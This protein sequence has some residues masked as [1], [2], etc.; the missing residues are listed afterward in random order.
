MADE[1]DLQIAQD[2]E[3]ERARTW[4]HQHG[5]SIVAGVALG[6]SAVVG[7]NYWQGYTQT[8]AKE[9]AVLYERFQDAIEE[10]ENAKESEENESDDNGDATDEIKEPGDAQDAATEDV[11]EADKVSEAKDNWQVIADDLMQEYAR[12]PYSNLA[13]FRLAKIAV[14]ENNLERAAEV[15]QWVLDNSAAKELSHVARLRLVT[16]KLSQDDAESALELLDTKQDSFRARYL[17]LRGDAELQLGN[18]NSAKNAYE[19]SLKSL[20]PESSAH[21]LVKLKLDSLGS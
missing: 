10:Y 20:P 13:A 16:V 7:F 18:I 9:A 15:L 2:P 3:L 5:K 12:T 17:E 14:D 8:Q 1:T 19:D 21:K 6:L 11:K 4:W